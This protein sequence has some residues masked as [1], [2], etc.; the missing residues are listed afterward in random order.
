MT[1]ID[2]HDEGITDPG[3]DA[4][5]ADLY[6]A[7]LAYSTGQGAPLCYIE[8]HKWFNLAALAGVPE[9]KVYRR[10]LSEL[11]SSADIAAAQASARQWLTDAAHGRSRAAAKPRREAEAAPRRTRVA[12]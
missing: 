11:M 2:A 7:G 10:E 5:G 9:A 1:S 3:A 12:A 6:R 4:T 8:A